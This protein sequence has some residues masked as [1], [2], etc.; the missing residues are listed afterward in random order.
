MEQIKLTYKE[1]VTEIEEILE[2]LEN[3]EL[4]I[5]QLAIKVKRVAVLLKY[6]KEKLT[7]TDTEIQSII[8]DL[9]KTDH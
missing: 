5:D 4:D 6:C 1:A 2:K 8:E 9:E 7:S 3:D